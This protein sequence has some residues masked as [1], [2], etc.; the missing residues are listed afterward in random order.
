MIGHAVRSG[1]RVARDVVELVDLE[2]RGVEDVSALVRAV[3]RVPRRVARFAR[4]VVM[5][6]AE[7]PTT[8]EGRPWRAFS[9]RFRAVHDGD[10]RPR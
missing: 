1:A 6:L 9:E 8:R 4:D 7:M 5:V 3:P 10:A 2:A